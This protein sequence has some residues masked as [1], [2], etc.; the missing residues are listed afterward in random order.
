[1]ILIII[2][3]LRNFSNK[4]NPGPGYYFDMNRDS[5]FFFKKYSLS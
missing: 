5:E 2:K 4:Q 1:M 3:N